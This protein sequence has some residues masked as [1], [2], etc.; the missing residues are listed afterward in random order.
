M[1]VEQD[2]QIESIEIDVDDIEWNNE[3]ANA[4]S[5][6]QNYLIGDWIDEPSLWVTSKIKFSNN[7]WDIS[8]KLHSRV[9]YFTPIRT[10]IFRVLLKH[11]AVR[12]LYISRKRKRNSTVYKKIIWI[13]E[14]ILYLEKKKY[15]YDLRYIT[16]EIVNEYVEDLMKVNITKDTLSRKLNAIQKF[17]EEI[18]IAGYDIDL[19][20]Y[21]KTL[22][23]VSLAELKA[24][25]E[26]GKTPNISK[27]IFKQTVKC[28]LTDIMDDSLRIQDRMMACQIVILAHTGMRKGEL[29]RL[30]EGKLRELSIFDDK[31]KA[32]FLE[33]FTYKT[34]A[35]KG[36]RWT[37]TIAYPETVKAYQIIEKVSEKRRA[38]GKTTYLHVNGNG[39]RYGDTAFYY[40]F[41]G[42][43]YRHQKEIFNNLSVF[44][45]TEV[46]INKVN[47]TF[48]MYL[49]NS[50][51]T[52]P[53]IGETFF[54]LNPH[55]FRV[56]MA[57][58]LKEEGKGLQWIMK[59]M[60]HMSEEMTKHYFRDDYLVQETLLRRASKDGNSL[61]VD[62]N[63][64]NSIISDELSEPE[65]LKAYQEINKFLKK[66]KFNIFKDIDEIIHILKY[67]P[68]RESIVGICTKQMG[69]L[70][71]RQYRLATM[72]KWYYLSPKVPNIDSFDFTYKRFI[73]KA[74]IVQHNKELVQQD[75]KYLRDYETEHRSFI[76]FYQ[77]RVL[78]E[79][80]LVLSLLNE[81][82]KDY[83]VSFYP[84]LE[85]I[86]S[87]INDVNKEIAKWAS[88]LILVHV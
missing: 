72:E 41:D 32:Y 59:H 80:E 51:S 65:L 40:S 76:K 28:A 37:E 54:T 63:N 79:Q 88:K 44:E 43:F 74:K 26:V 77:N 58:R 71:E 81:K 8:S 9:L 22:N 75:S 29:Q 83:I 78:P 7:I 82:G 86:V 27:R 67:N 35:A 39:K 48:L 45:K 34:T 21:Q 30:E 64:Q 73:D 15:M 1:I 70:C 66:K 57:N 53:V 14:F 69:I 13:R 36:G 85:A 25:R 5:S 12:D 18:N 24:D 31:E 62:S 61:E 10:K 33:F 11:I 84:Q 60:N 68:L 2:E 55:Q 19:S 50:V 6:E 47:S 4:L 16:P 42:F 20:D 3:I 56:F 17:L 52:T 46:H 38:F 87:N 49:G 23:R